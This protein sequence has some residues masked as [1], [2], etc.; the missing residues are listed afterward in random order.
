MGAL[1]HKQSTRSGEEQ[2][3]EETSFSS[4]SFDATITTT[5]TAWPTDLVPADDTKAPQY[6]GNKKEA[7]NLTAR[8]RRRRRRPPPPPSMLQSLQQRPPVLQPTDWAPTDEA[9][10]PEN[11]EIEEETADGTEGGQWALPRAADKGG[12]VHRLLSFSSST[13]LNKLLVSQLVPRS[14]MRFRL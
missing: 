1:P 7:A 9:E 14:A 12:G 10:A 2:E 13:S 6:D 11:E 8:R 4:S 5:E 3:E